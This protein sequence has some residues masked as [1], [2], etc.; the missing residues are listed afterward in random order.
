MKKLKVRLPDG[1]EIEAMDVDFETVKEDW[2]E[3]KL[4]DGTILKFKTIVSSIVRTEEYDPMTG[5]PVYHVR[6]TNV[7]R[8]KVPEELK[9]LPGARK[10]DVEG[11]E[12]R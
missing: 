4:E 1:R 11:V 2:N 7:L 12:V 5:D 6:S 3:Y 8:V 9:R 10:S